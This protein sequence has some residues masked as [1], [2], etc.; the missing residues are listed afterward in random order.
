MIRMMMW[1]NDTQDVDFKGLM[2]DFVKFY[3]NRPATTEDFKLAVEQHMNAS[4]NLTG[5]GKMDW[6]FDEYVYGTAL[7][8]EK[9]GYAF[10]NA[11]DGSIVLNFKVEQSGVDQH[12]RVAVPIYIELADGG[13]FRVG[14]V[15]LT[16]NTAF[17]NQVTLHGL[18][19][20]P[21]RAMLNYY[22]DVLCNQN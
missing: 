12:F 7:P 9:L 5:D 15:P 18:K 19:T 10:S 21:K 4:M 2:H 16:G 20:K 17:E 13:I 22:H 8:T 1:S 11:P 6:F 3:T 14:S